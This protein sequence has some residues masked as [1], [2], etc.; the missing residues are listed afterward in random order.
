[1]AGWELALIALVVAWSLQSV[2]VWYQMRRYSRAVRRLREEY[3]DGYLGTGF[4]KSRFGRGTIAL[5]VTGDDLVVRR[6]AIMTGRSILANFHDHPGLAGIRL[7]RLDTALAETAEFGAG[8]RAAVLQ[9][10]TQIRERR[11]RREEE[12][13]EAPDGLPCPE[14]P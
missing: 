4:T 3:G 8:E 13:E 1:M 9:A 2:G 14:S 10:A 12:E 5:V 7:D 11:N 6:V